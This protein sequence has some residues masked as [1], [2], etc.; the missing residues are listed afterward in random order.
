VCSVLLKC[1]CE[2][3]REFS[4][5]AHYS[6]LCLNTVTTYGVEKGAEKKVMDDW[7]LCVF[8]QQKGWIF[9]EIPL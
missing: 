3:V 6:M 2:E 9:A 4:K 5:T 1:T 8:F 7:E